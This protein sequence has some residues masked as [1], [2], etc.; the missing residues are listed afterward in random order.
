VSQNSSLQGA[1]LVHKPQ[2]ISS[3]GVIDVLKKVIRAE[4]EREL[5]QDDSTSTGGSSLAAG[6]G[7]ISGAATERKRVRFRELPK[8]GHGG[9]LDP[10]ATGLLIV[11]I[12]R[13]VKLS[14]YFLGSIKKYEACLRFGETTIP[15]DP[16]EEISERSPNLPSS[17]D[18]LNQLAQTFRS[19][20]YS[21]IPPMHS[22]KK[23][24]GQV[25]Y[26][27]AREGIEIERAPK[28]CKL[29]EF[30]FLDFEKA[31]T[32]ARSN[33]RVTCTSGTYIRTLSQD[34]SRRLNTVGM[35][36]T[37]HRSGS[38]IF[39]ITESTTL[40]ELQKISED[41]GS[42]EKLRGF[43][44]FDRLL[45]GY[46]SVAATFEE[47]EALV[48]GKQHVLESILK[49]IGPPRSKLATTI[50]HQNQAAIY[51]QDRLIATAV[52]AA[53]TTEQGEQRAWGLERVFPEALGDK[54]LATSP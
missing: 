6:S 1:L 36:D 29:H 53:A 52:F 28:V 31:G 16:T 32:I 33:F 44:P 35:L 14:R 5:N 23:V 54:A 37:L 3:F 25:L 17:L 20:D 47:A 2:G 43:I 30:E 34:F 48:H 21:Q 18:E 51:Y 11:C 27:L 7:T 49:K 9:T 19:Q 40:E 50:D 10:F 22:A 13:G 24:G 12:G 8:L 15:G 26:E 38:G 39:R 45:D 4:M 41:G 46:P 42:W